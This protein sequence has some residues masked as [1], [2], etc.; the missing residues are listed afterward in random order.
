[1]VHREKHPSPMPL[2][3]G[4]GHLPV[5][6]QLGVG[7]RRRPGRTGP[8]GSQFEYFTG[9]EPT[10][11]CS[12]VSLLDRYMGVVALGWSPS[13]AAEDKVETGRVETEQNPHPLHNSLW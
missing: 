5:K 13:R 1:M 3:W 11:G 10:C 9:S 12:L 4:L 2:Q 8:A 6:S 7:L